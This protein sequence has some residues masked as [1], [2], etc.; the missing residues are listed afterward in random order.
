MLGR[1]HFDLEVSVGNAITFNGNKENYYSIFLL[2]IHPPY[3]H[4]L[5]LNL[6]DQF[7]N[8][9]LKKNDLLFIIR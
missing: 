7:S 8:Q 2:A 9:A 5:F 3:D 6:N 4:N 1:D